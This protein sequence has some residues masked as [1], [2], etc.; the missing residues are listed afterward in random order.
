MDNIQTFILKGL[1]ED[2]AFFKNVSS[3]LSPTFFDEDK[4]KIIAYIKGYY[5]KY[6]I[7]PDYSVV[8]NSICNM[9]SVSDEVKAEAEKTIAEVKA[10]PFDPIKENGWLFDQTR[11]FC[12][13]RA[14]F[15]ALKDGAMEI[16]KEEGKRDYGKIEKKMR[17]ALSLNWNEDLGIDYFDEV[18]FDNTY[19]E[20]SDNT[21]RIPLGVDVIDNAINGGIPGKTKFVVTFIGAAGI[22]KCVR[23]VNTITIRNKLTGEV[24]TLPIS[25]F[26]DSIRG[27][28]DANM[29]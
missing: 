7:V 21:I 24:K 13:N 8:V 1:L 15:S 9:K 20:L 4:S 25:E 26:H 11:E 2:P 16:S 6:E 18:E 27:K 23:G 28:R 12:N 22:G 5:A 17:D 3:N 29:L 19:D 10:L 14:M